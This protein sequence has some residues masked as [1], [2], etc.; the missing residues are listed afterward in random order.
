MDDQTRELMFSSE[1][2]EWGTPQDL[3]DELDAKHKFTVDLAANEKNNKHE[4][5]IRPEDN[6]FSIRPDGV[7]FINP[8]YNKPEHPC[9]KKCVKKACIKR[10]WHRKEYLPGQIDFVR[11]VYELAQEGILTTVALLPARTDTKIFHQFIWDKNTNS[12]KDGVELE[13]L[14]G[15]LKF[16]LQNGTKDPAPFPSMVV[17]FKARK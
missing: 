14:E 9:K 12:P 2:S 10:G 17:V 6:L 8:P 7:G 4:N 11:Y 1:A 3:Y 15:R 5:F 16:D 13:F